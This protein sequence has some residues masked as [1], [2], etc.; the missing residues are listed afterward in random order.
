MLGRVEV[1]TRTK[2]DPEAD[3]VANTTEAAVGPLVAG[4]GD[5][6]RLYKFLR[7]C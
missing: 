4:R 7:E 6:R 5:A 2:F 3:E 1:V